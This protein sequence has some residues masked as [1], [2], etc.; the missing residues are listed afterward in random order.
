MAAV[1]DGCVIWEWLH[2]GEYCPSFAFC[3]P[4]FFVD[5]IR[6]NK[7]RRRARARRILNR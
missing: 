6:S 1:D 7:F 3:F 2:F 4:I 5:E